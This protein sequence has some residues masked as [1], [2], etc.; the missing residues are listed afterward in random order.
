M[1]GCIKCFVRYCY[2]LKLLITMSQGQT[3][4]GWHILNE[5]KS[6]YVLVDVLSQSAD[7]E[8]TKVSFHG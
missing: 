8:K 7:G 4:K 5:Q 1:E 6:K 3:R 2:N